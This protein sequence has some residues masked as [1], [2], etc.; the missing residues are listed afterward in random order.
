MRNAMLTTVAPTGTI[1]ILA[2]CSAGVEPLYSVAFTR[3]ILDGEKLPEVHPYFRE[4][5]E[6]EGFASPALFET[7]AREGSV[8]R[9]DGV[10]AA[11]RAVFACAHD[12]APEDH[13]RMQAAFQESTDNAVSK[14]VNLPSGASPDDVRRAFELAI[15]LGVKGVT[16]YRDGSR[17]TQ[18]MALSGSGAVRDLPSALGRLVSL[19]AARG[20]GADEI[21][22][23]LGGPAAAT[24]ASN[25]CPRCGLPLVIQE[26][27]E[28]CSCGYGKC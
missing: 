7:A 26:G 1:S 11:W 14:T 3:Q 2:G 18:P 28:Q 21:A 22:A 9:I 13:L 12:V 15:D 16:V 17:A 23:A 8:R 24:A 4:V 20:A 25:P 27:C 19:A 5:A 6:R 10:P